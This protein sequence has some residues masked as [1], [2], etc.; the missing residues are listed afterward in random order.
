MIFVAPVLVTSR[1][2]RPSTR[3]SCANTSCVM[4][5]IA[6]TIGLKCMP[7][8]RALTPV[9]DWNQIL[10]KAGHNVA[11]AVQHEGVRGRANNPLHAHDPWRSAATLPQLHL[12]C[13]L[14]D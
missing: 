14:E 10:R 11:D 6:G 3:G 5:I 8:P 7:D 9:M 1:V 12:D 4:L 13:R 2:S